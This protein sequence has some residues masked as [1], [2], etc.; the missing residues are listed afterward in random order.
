MEYFKK[1]SPAM[2]QFIGFYKYRKMQDDFTRSFRK[3]SG[4]LWGCLKI[5]EKDGTPQIKENAMRLQNSFEGHRTKFQGVYKFWQQ[6]ENE[7]SIDNSEEGECL[8]NSASDDHNFNLSE[9]ESSDM[10]CEEKE[11]EGLSETEFSDGGYEEK[12]ESDKRK[13]SESDYEPTSSPISSDSSNDREKKQKI[14]KRKKPKAKVT[15][16]HEKDNCSSNEDNPIPAAGGDV[17]SPL[18]PIPPLPSPL[19]PPH[20]V[21]IPKDL[22]TPVNQDQSSLIF[23]NPIIQNPVTPPPRSMMTGGDVESLPLQ[24]QL[25]SLPS[26]LLPPSDSINSINNVIIP[27]FTNTIVDTSG[28]LPNVNNIQI[29]PQKL[30]LFKESISYLQNHIK[31]DVNGQ[32]IITKDN[33]ISG[34]ISDIIR[35]WLVKTL[36]SPKEEFVKA[37]MTPLGSEASPKDCDFRQICEYILYDF[38]FMTKKGP[39]KRNIG[40]R[41]YIVERIAPLFKSIQSIYNEYKFH[42]IEVELDCMREVKKIFPRSKKLKEDS[43]K[44]LNEAIF[45]LV[46]LLRNYLDKSVEESKQLY[47]F[48]IQGIGDRLTLS[49]LCLIDKHVYKVSQ[50]KSATLPFDFIDVAEYLAVFEFLYILVSELEIQTGIINKLRLSKSADGVNIPRIRDWIWLPD[51]ISAWEREEIQNENL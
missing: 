12:Q 18:L 13:L 36:M 48:M 7:T 22:P 50:M 46:S 30:M 31:I 28:T 1:T 34:G 19:L 11:G 21:I 9:T 37:I 45:G 40:E 32:G 8:E 47:T 5:L 4:I 26:P 10:D 3:E 15:V 43:E 17:V 2:F 49:K 20:N 38:Y 24:S 23:T 33:H 6:I 51:S 27:L 16:R 14:S 35:N 44:L 29:T 39:L 41:T 25:L 42:W